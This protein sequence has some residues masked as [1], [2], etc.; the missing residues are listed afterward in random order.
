[1]M[2]VRDL[3]EKHGKVKP[4]WQLQDTDVPWKV[5]KGAELLKSAT[6]LEGG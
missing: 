2:L 4:N 3:E 6:G 5:E 1:M